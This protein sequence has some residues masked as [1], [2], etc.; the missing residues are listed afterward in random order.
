M[1]VCVA[2]T[3]NKDHRDRM[4]FFGNGKRLPSIYVLEL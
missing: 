2:S 3:V 1:F 4:F